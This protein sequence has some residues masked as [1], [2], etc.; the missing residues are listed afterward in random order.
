MSVPTVRIRVEFY[1]IARA[2]AGVADAFVQLPAG[3]ATLGALI[4]R[5][6]GQFAELE[7][8]FAGPRL[9][10]GFT[11]NIDGDRFV[12]SPDAVVRNGEIVLIMS[13]DAGG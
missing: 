4:Q 3:N 5:L 13:A 11:A 1:G 7:E 10:P 6:G 2:R 8:C 12:T 9:R